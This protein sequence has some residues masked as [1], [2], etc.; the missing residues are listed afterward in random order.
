MAHGLSASGPRRN[1]IDVWIL[2]DEVDPD[3]DIDVAVDCDILTIS[4]E[5]RESSREKQGIH[6][7][8]RGVPLRQRNGDLLEI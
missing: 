3:R 1:L 5:R 6:S 7:E 8:S 2:N 4:A